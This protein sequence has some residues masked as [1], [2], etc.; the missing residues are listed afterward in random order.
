MKK[1]NKKK[2]NKNIMKGEKYMN[3]SSNRGFGINEI[4]GISAGL[5]IAVII[6]LP[7]LRTLATD[8]MGNLS[9]WWENIQGD[10]F[11]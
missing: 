7:G 4:I 11:G 10:L 3:I 2:R 8:I 1:L 6:V 9:T 5:I